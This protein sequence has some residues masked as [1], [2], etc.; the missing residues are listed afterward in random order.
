[1]NG[2]IGEPGDPGQPG[3]QG[4]QG[5]LDQETLKWLVNKIFMEELGAMGITTPQT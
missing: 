2:V 5:G 3:E 4:P 1:L